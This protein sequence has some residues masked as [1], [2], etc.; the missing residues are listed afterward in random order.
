MTLP[1]AHPLHKPARKCATHTVKCHKSPLHKLM[2]T[3][4]VQP[5]DIE[6]I[7]PALH[8][9]ALTH[10]RPF[11]VSIP[12]NKDVSIVEDTQVTEHIKVYSDGS[13]HN[14]NVGAAAILCRAREPRRT[15]HFHLGPSTHHTVHEAELISM[16]LG[17]HMIKME[18]KGKTS[19]ALGVDNQAALSSLNAVKMA[20]G[21]YITDVILETAACI[22]K[23]KSSV[24]YSLKFRWTAG[25]VGIDGNEEVNVEAKK[26]AEGVTSDKKVL[27]LLLRKPLKQNKSALKQDKRSRLK[28][29]WV[30]EWR[31]S[32]R[33]NKI[34][35]IDTSL[36][37]NKFLK[38]ISDDR[39]SRTDI[40]RIC[41]LRTGH[42]PL[43]TYLKRIGRATDASCP[44]CGH[45]K[46]DVRHF[47]VDCP[48]Y[49]HKRWTLQ[50]HSKTRNPSLK[51]LLNERKLIVPVA[52]YIQAT[53]QFKQEGV[54]GQGERG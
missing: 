12:A 42:I 43:N 53:G 25:H 10:K 23:T 20:P 33:Y 30:Q 37:S 50:R 26:A 21:Q 4:N 27:L 46:E 29:H 36:P 15:L 13:S 3:Y 45:P 7:R 16:L 41:Q 9:L 6:C 19:Y 32:P 49:A 11:T 34:K 31:V 51:K 35:A 2:N 1:T 22:K 39:L 44:A 5:K 48:A 8:N 47:L 14:G 38:L 17:L 28:T 52:N 54:P 40:S 24:S 18:K